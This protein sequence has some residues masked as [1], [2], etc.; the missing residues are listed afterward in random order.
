VD[1][2]ARTVGLS[3]ACILLNHAANITADQAK[4]LTA[5]ISAGRFFL[6]EKIAVLA[7]LA[8]RPALHELAGEFACYI[9]EQIRLDDD[10]GGLGNSYVKLAASLVPSE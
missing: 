6:P 5:L 1:S 9:A 8:E 10:I 3:C 7:P 4:T 2:P